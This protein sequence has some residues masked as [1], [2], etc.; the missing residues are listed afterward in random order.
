MAKPRFNLKS[1]GEKDSYIFLVY[2]FPNQAN[3][4][5]RYFTGCSVPVALWNDKEQRVRSNRLFPQY[6]QI[7]AILSK[8]V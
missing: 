3:K 1:K 6:S 2:S 4:R 7:N 5:L 8:L